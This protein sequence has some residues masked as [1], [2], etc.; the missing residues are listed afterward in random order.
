[1]PD[2][3]EPH[4]EWIK[5][6]ES[7]F[8]F[9]E[10]LARAT[11]T[12]NTDRA[13]TLCA[14]LASLQGFGNRQ[15]AFFAE[16]FD[17]AKFP[18]T[19]RHPLYA[20]EYFFD[21]TLNQIGYDTDVLLRAGQ[22]RSIRLPPQNEISSNFDATLANAD[23]LAWAALSPAIRTKLIQPATA[24]VYYQKS[25]SVRL[26]PYAPVAWVGIPYSATG[27][28]RDLAA[29]AHEVGHFVASRLVDTAAA[30]GVKANTGSHRPAQRRSVVHDR[31]SLGAEPPVGIASLWLSGWDGEVFADVYACMVSGPMSG[32][33]ML[34]SLRR[35]PATRWMEDDREHPLPILRPRI[36][37]M[38]L[39]AMARYVDPALGCLLE[40][41]AR[42]LDDATD[43]WLGGVLP[44]WL[45]FTPRGG[46][47][48]RI[49]LALQLMEDAV[50]RLVRYDLAL[51]RPQGNQPGQLWTQPPY[52]R[53]HISRSI[54]DLLTTLTD[55]PPELYF[56][57][58][59]PPSAN[60]GTAQSELWTEGATGLDMDWELARDGDAGAVH[61]LEQAGWNPWWLAVLSAG[62]WTTEGPGAGN[63]QPP[64]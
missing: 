48:M 29:I 3:Q 6:K 55:A 16:K 26:L 19:P 20:P 21:V 13:G 60:S 52:G 51:L 49:T 50:N 25:H 62:F 36:Y 58:P 34:D 32:F 56:G 38:T 33:T 31:R 37:A 54:E 43:A 61:V 17:N 2:N 47:P 44:E 53:E 30:A 42:L 40:T 5:R 18:A 35:L 11:I 1:M 28:E 22:Q 27:T 64:S 7:I 23:R 24:F 14:L 10:V 57:A 41:T 15:F 9:Q 8:K 12:E 45:V 39:R 46:S 59:P 4:A 63:P